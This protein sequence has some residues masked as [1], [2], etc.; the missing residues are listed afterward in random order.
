M[1]LAEQVVE[2]LKT[3]MDNVYDAGYQKGKSEGG[4]ID[5]LTS[6]FSSVKFSAEAMRTHTED[7]ELYLPN[8][9]DFS[10]AFGNIPIMFSKLS[11]TISQKCTTFQNT[12]RATSI[13]NEAEKI[14]L[15]TIEIIGD[16]SGITRYTNAFAG[17]TGLEEIIGDLNGS[18][19]MTFSNAFNQL[20]L[21]REV[22]FVA[23]TIKVSISFPQSS[24]LSAESIQSIID[25]LADLT[26]ATAQTIIFNANV[27]AKLTEEQIATITSKN[28]TLA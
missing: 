5:H 28:W 25:G 22:R 19:A 18:S 6:L 3:D 17:R 24:E 8:V 23:E 11:V 1:S 26:G 20:V 15:K 27:K 2:Q 13:T 10:D 21:L 16:T 14:N 9:S 12:F 4:G 7:M